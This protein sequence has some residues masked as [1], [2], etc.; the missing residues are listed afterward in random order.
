M[1]QVGVIVGIHASGHSG[2]PFD[3]VEFGRCSYIMSRVGG[4]VGLRS[5]VL[6]ICLIR[7]HTNALAQCD[8]VMITMDFGIS[9]GCYQVEGVKT[10]NYSGNSV[11]K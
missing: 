8:T 4:I 2:A 9:P 11:V 7:L 10:L 3:S 5:M 6:V 1:S